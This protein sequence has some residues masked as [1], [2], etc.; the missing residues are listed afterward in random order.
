MHNHNVSTIQAI[1]ELLHMHL[2]EGEAFCV[3]TQIRIEELFGKQVNVIK[4][5]PKIINLGCVGAARSGFLM[6]LL[7]LIA[8]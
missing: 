6:G 7:Y 2:N 8:I 5:A 4:L 1:S 3:A